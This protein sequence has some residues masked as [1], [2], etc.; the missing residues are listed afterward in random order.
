MSAL[1]GEPA[2]WS[3]YLIRTG[4]GSLYTGV[5]TDVQ[6]RFAEHE[7]TDKKNKGAKALRGRGPL[8][9]VFKIV[10]GDR[11][12][13]LKLEYR[14]KQ[15]SRTDKERL[16]GRGTNLEELKTWLQMA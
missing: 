16:I 9:L 3:L 14:I 15:L 1:S 2:P 7:N 11:S 10:V 5:S 8:N 4:D 6:R 13:A 12:D